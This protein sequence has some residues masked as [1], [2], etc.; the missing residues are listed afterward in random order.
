MGR[1]GRTDGKSAELPI[2]R[3]QVCA[4]VCVHVPTSVCMY[5]HVRVPVWSC[6]RVGVGRVLLWKGMGGQAGSSCVHVHWC[7]SLCVHVH[8][9]CLGVVV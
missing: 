5:V 8:A 4:C 7:V 6:A 1:A 2:V 3:C 9:V